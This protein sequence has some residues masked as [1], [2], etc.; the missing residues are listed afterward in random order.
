[1]SENSAVTILRSPSLSAVSLTA[2]G[3]L[4]LA[5]GDSPAKLAEVCKTPTSEPT[6]SEAPQLPQKLASGGFWE[7]HF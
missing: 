6:P 3:S 1:M 7:P 5:D 2:C 4:W